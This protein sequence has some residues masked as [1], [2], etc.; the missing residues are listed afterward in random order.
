MTQS[1]QETPPIQPSTSVSLQRWLHTLG[2]ASEPTSWLRNYTKKPLAIYPMDSSGYMLTG[3]WENH[4]T[5][6]IL[7]PSQ[8]S[9]RPRIRITPLRTLHGIAKVKMS[10]L[11]CTAK[12]DDPEIRF[13]YSE[14][15][16]QYAYI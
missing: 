4:S 5:S 6:I 16:D 14:N 9:M 15:V 12:K 10:R 7:Q 1:P 13:V 3:F 8:I 2:F 11:T